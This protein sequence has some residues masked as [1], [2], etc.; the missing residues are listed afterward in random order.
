MIVAT[1]Y[2]KPT[3]SGGAQIVIW[4]PSDYEI[5]ASIHAFDHSAA[6]P[7]RAALI[8][9]FGDVEFEDLGAN[10]PFDVKMK[11]WVEDVNMRTWKVG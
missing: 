6:D 2:M 4:V 11:S 7:H 1:K 8:E 10:L 9:A 3:E 5:E